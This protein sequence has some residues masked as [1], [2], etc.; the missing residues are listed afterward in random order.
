MRKSSLLVLAALALVLSSL[1]ITSATAQDD[2]LKFI[3]KSNQF[4]AI[5]VGSEGESLGD[6]VVFNDKLYDEDDR[7]EKVGTLDGFCVTTY[8]KKKD[9]RM[10][11]VVTM[12][13][14]DG[15]I[16]AQGVLWS[17]DD[18]FTIAV[19]GGTDDYN[20]AAGDADVEF[21]NDEKAK[22]EVNLN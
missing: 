13:L 18:E 12:K 6:H 21:V 10:E 15:Q 8:V 9:S 14:D 5:D 4:K 1:A 17:D 7:D 19:T 3:A 16:T 2:D 11:C 22:I 20:D